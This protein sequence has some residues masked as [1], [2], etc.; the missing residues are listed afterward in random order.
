[1]KRGVENAHADLLVHR[2]TVLTPTV[3][4]PSHVSESVR[5]FW[6]ALGA[7]VRIMSPKAHDVALAMTSHLPHLIAAGLAGLLPDELYELAA[8]GFRDTTRVASGGPEIWTPILQQNRVS[9][10][11]GLLELEKRLHQFAQALC[12]DDGV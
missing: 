1:E 3:K 7:K 4:T 5:E 2:I 10:L 12:K 6:Q 9:L 8:T 11:T